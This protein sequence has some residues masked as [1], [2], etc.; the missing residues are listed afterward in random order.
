ML[1]CPDS[2]P[3]H[4]NLSLIQS[5][6]HRNSKV[7]EMLKNWEKDL[8]RDGASEPAEASAGGLQR[9]MN[10]ILMRVLETFE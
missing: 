4:G 2:R 6:S 9:E 10:V 7:A 5:L 8:G 1:E 3:L